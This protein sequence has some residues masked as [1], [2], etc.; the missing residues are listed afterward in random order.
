MK[1][2]NGTSLCGECPVSIGTLE[3]N[4]VLFACL[5]TRLILS[6][7]SSLSVNPPVEEPEPK[8]PIRLKLTMTV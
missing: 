7:R 5:V 2:G 1:T 8:A 6:Q 3:D 4:S